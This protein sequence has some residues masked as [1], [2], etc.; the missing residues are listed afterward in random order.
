MVED[1]PELIEFADGSLLAYACC[2]NVRWKKV[3]TNQEDPNRYVVQLVCTKARV[4]S[5]AYL[6]CRDS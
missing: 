3:K 4:T 5:T 6:N 1:V 2:I